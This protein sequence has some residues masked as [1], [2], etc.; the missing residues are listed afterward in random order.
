VL[1][2]EPSSDQQAYSVHGRVR[3]GLEKEIVRK[4]DALFTYGR[5]VCRLH[6]HNY[7]DV[8]TEKSET[9]YIDRPEKYR[10]MEIVLRDKASIQSDEQ[11][12]LIYRKG[13]RH[14]FTVEVLPDDRALAESVR[15]ITTPDGLRGIE[16]CV[17]GQWLLLVHNPGESTCMLSMSRPWAEGALAL[18]VSGSHT[19]A[20]KPLDAAGGRIEVQ[21]PPH[22][23][24]VVQKTQ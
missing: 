8:I 11:K 6:E 12:P 14:F 7:A 21:I 23:H 3:F 19:P 5:M 1:E 13:T 24:I 16:F 20:P 2:I 15:R 9:F 18:H 10:S 22:S 17:R 4:E